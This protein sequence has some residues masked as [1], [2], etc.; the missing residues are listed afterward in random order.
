MNPGYINPTGDECAACAI[1]ALCFADGPI[2]DFE[3][4]GLYGLFGLW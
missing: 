1:C 4:I 3:G 2:P